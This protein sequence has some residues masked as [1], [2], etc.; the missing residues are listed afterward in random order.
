MSGRGVTLCGDVV[1]RDS[2]HGDTVWH[3]DSLR[4]GHIQGT[5]GDMGWG[6]WGCEPHGWTCGDMGL[7][8]WK[9]PSGM[10]GH[11]VEGGGGSVR[12]EGREWGQQS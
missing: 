6:W 8:M 4:G 11:G 1:W 12:A 5:C 3:G 7:G 9:G 2:A 10:W